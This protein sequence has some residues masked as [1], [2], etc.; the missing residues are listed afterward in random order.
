MKESFIYKVQICTEQIKG[1]GSLEYCMC[2]YSTLTGSPENK[3][4]KHSCMLETDPDQIHPHIHIA[5]KIT[6]NATTKCVF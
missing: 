1:S 5:H 2:H 4:S 6:R 3:D